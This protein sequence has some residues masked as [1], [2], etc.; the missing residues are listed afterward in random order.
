MF[1]ESA[2]QEELEVQVEQSHLFALM[3]DIPSD[4]LKD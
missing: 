2:E 3:K 4:K 1:I